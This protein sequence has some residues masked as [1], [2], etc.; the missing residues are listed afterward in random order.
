MKLW[1]KIKNLFKP[2]TIGDGTPYVVTV[3]EE[4]EEVYTFSTDEQDGESLNYLL[5][6][7]Q[8]YNNY[9]INYDITYHRIT[10]LFT[11]KKTG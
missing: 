9:S 10:V 11:K 7:F 2:R 8:R 1:D 3:Y 4:G 5:S 6:Y